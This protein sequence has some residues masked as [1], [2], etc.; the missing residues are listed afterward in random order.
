MSPLLTGSQI[1]R[2]G[3]SAPGGGLLFGFGLFVSRLTGDGRG[4]AVGGRFEV[5]SGVAT[6]ELTVIRGNERL[7]PGQDVTV[8]GAS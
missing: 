8:A 1:P 5:I 2:H 7:R 3:P 4:V 6:G